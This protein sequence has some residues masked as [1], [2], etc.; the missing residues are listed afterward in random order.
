MSVCLCV[1]FA[2]F[3]SA[4]VFHVPRGWDY[5]G[6]TSMCIEYVHVREGLCVSLYRRVYEEGWVFGCLVYVDVCLRTLNFRGSCV[7]CVYGG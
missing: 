3:V 1:G 2:S 6:S 4:F 5:F 7:M